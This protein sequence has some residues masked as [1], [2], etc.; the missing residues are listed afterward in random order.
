M[1]LDI[2]LFRSEK[3]GNPDQVRESLRR[4]Y[5]DPSLVDTI[6]SK[7]EEW[8]KQRFS[9]DNLNKDYNAANKQV[10]LKKKESKG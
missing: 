1:G 8:R 9:L 5:K 10:A 7:D 2:N 6:I 3:G 4:R